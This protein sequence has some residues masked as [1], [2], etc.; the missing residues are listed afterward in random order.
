MFHSDNRE[1]INF[2]KIVFKLLLRFG[3]CCDK[4]NILTVFYNF[5][6]V[7]SQC[8]SKMV[9]FAW[10]LELA[11]IAVNIY[12]IGKKIVAKF[13]RGMPFNVL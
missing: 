9:W 5:I 7:V 1:E 3:R 10:L 4:T 2:F 13:T 11:Y 12:Y 8:S 6:G